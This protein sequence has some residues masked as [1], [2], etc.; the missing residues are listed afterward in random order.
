MFKGA[1]G[2]NRESTH[3][4]SMV[5]VAEAAVTGSHEASN[6]RRFRTLLDSLSTFVWV[7]D[8]HG[9]FTTPQSGWEEY[10]GQGF[11]EHR[12]TAW[13]TAVHP[14]DRANVAMV[15]KEAVQSKSWYEV[16]WR[17]WHG[18]TR[19]WRQCITRGVPVTD[20]DG[21]VVQWFGAVQDVEDRLDP[22]L[23]RL[24][25]ELAARTAE[26]DQTVES[27]TF[28]LTRC[29]RDLRYI[30]ANPAYARIAGVPLEHIVGRPIA[31]VMGAQGFSAIRPYVER[32]L[33]GEPVY[34]E[35]SV[36]FSGSGERVLSVDY[37][38]W[39]EADGSV[40]GWIA[41]VRDITER[42]HAEES[43]RVSEERLRLAAEIAKMG[44]FDLD[45][46]TGVSKWTSEMEAMHGLATGQFA[47]TDA[48]WEALVHPEDRPG[49]VARVNEAIE[50]GR[51]IECEWRVI[52]PD[53]TEHW[54]AARL[55]ALRDDQGKPIRLVGV[56][57]DIT[58]QKNYEKS[59]ERADRLKDEFLAML[60]HELRNP[61]A[62]IRNAAEI[63]KHLVGSDE[64][65]QAPL[66]M[67][68]RQTAQ[69]TR[70]VDQLLDVSRIS[71]GRITLELRVVE[72]GEIIDHAV[73][74]VQP[75]ISDNE[76]QLSIERPSESIF[77][78]GD[79][80]RLAQVLGNVLN[81]AAKYTDR[82][83]HIQIGV[84]VTEREVE[85]QVTDNGRGISADL[86]PHIFDLFVQSE[87]T[88]DRA[89]GGL[90][91]GLAVVKRLVE[92]HGG[93]VKAQSQGPG[94]GSTITVQLLRSQPPDKLEGRGALVRGASRRILI[95]DDNR[96]GADSLSA[97][98]SLQGHQVEAVYSA[99]DGLEAALNSRPE[100]IL[101]DIGLPQI[102]GYELARRMRVIDSL[103]HVTI[104]ALTGYGQP[105]D[106]ERALAAGFDEHLVK[107]AKLDD[108][109]RL[110]AASAER[111]R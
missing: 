31:E 104:I 16:A 102:D 45:L 73:E 6:D 110:L 66:G 76:H 87:R 100:V 19:S 48:A 38:P 67:L 1:T 8:A 20:A 54:L 60:A 46:R 83:G 36:S 101:I 5:R 93:S 25:E 82:N 75:L 53:G 43:L 94:C 81:N 57:L 26:L 99:R 59:L 23:K 34:H 92:L 24:Q 89:Q 37:T 109:A 14:D 29:G 17:C 27:V 58:A 13:M 77:V 30:T 85:L 95:I 72:I 52:W 86:L 50:T 108:I 105:R 70:L 90:G 65:T 44:A 80:A 69:L 4:E 35:T 32:V 63:L 68:S 28:G 103:R 79:P 2:D 7:A 71:Q 91:V 41:S 62:P 106:R 22:E 96:D 21:S 33:R 111:G 97:L 88:L 12:G 56:N 74:S 39:R 49:A 98:L 42:R 61:L 84:S 18:P 78:Q 47:G 51:A 10:T 11:D 55:Q 40:S 107:P 64:R 9:E 15:W 3:T